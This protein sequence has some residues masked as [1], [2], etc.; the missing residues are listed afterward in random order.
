MRC[1]WHVRQQEGKANGG[2]RYSRDNSALLCKFITFD[3]E[4]TRQ[5]RKGRRGISFI[6][7]VFH[8]Y[9]KGLNE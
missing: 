3:N 6:D 1:H 4:Y 9:Y 5:E 2:G 7:T 8:V